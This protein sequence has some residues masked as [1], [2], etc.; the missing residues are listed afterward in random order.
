[1]SSLSDEYLLTRDKSFLEEIQKEI[2]YFREGIEGKL[3]NSF[4]E[5]KRIRIDRQGLVEERC[6]SLFEQLVDIA[7]VLEEEAQEI[8][9]KEK[10]EMETLEEDIYSKTT[11][12]IE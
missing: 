11:N 3:K 8:S 9:N 10:Q 1:M 12:S 2:V 6:K 5:T 4:D 7:F